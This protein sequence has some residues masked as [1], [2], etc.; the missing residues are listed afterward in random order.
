MTM[1]RIGTLLFTCFL[2]LA[3]LPLDNGAP[4]PKPKPKSKASKVSI[5]Y[6]YYF[7]ILVLRCKNRGLLVLFKVI[8][9]FCNV[10]IYSSRGPKDNI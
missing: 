10:V 9:F 7:K 6:F 3:I 1:D 4:K 2:L 5:F 8:N